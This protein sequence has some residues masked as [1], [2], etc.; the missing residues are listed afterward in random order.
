MTQILSIGVDSKTPKGEKFGVS[1]AIQYQAPNTQSGI[2]NVCVYASEGCIEAC[3]Y[4]AGHGVKP[5]VQDARI[6]RTILFMH[7]RQTYWIKLIFEIARH[8]RRADKAGMVPAV[9]LNGTSDVKWEATPV[10]ING[11]KVAK[12]IM[13]LYPTV[14]FYDYTKYPYHKRPAESL[15]ANYDLTFSRSESNDDEV[16]ENLRL[17]RR[18]A[19]VF[20]S[21]PGEI[22]PRTY[23]TT[24]GSIWPV[25][26]GDQSDVR[27]YDP[28][29]VVVALHAKGKA[30]RD[31]SGF[32]VQI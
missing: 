30:R 10:V 13:A 5:S 23:T 2:A 20:N 12:N 29:G 26:D 7:D 1:T 16:L 32:V 3:L 22:P 31:H 19:V 15:P 8:K 25:V 28:A 21:K 27:F 18:V 11:A 14:Q 6:A 24:D 17:G 9:R 4:T